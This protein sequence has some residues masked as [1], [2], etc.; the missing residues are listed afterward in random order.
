MRFEPVF[1][2]SPEP[3]ASE[4]RTVSRRA[5]L[6]AVIGSFGVGTAVGLALSA[7]RVEGEAPDDGPA[8][9]PAEVPGHDWALR[10]QEGPLED[11]AARYGTFLMVFASA[12]D[13]RL[14]LGVER[15]VE[16][17]LSRDPLVEGQRV[18]LAR[19]LVVEIESRPIA[20]PLARHA[21]ALGRIR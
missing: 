16:A 6:T 9:S 19:D 21:E 2:V 10:I 5:F 7:G 8:E 18:E 4:P 14:L 13:A 20:A 1:L 11:L 15:L 17:V 3:E 12:N